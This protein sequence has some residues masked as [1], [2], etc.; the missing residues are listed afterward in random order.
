MSLVEKLLMPKKLLIAA[1]VMMATLSLAICAE[2][3]LHFE[4]FRIVKSVFFYLI[5]DYIWTS[6][7][8]EWFG[9]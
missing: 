1:Y 5:L 2:Y 4:T 8:K 3:F 7:R 9:Q 6:V